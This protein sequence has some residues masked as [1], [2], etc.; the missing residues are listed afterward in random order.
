MIP[1]LA[2]VR[3]PDLGAQLIPRILILRRTLLRSFVMLEN[4]ITNRQAGV[5]VAFPLRSVLPVQ[6][7]W[8]QVV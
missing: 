8:V 3:S 7:I 4:L 5:T 1:L 2:M 6:E